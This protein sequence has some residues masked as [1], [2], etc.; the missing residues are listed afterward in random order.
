[1]S[2]RLRLMLAL[3]AIFALGFGAL[4]VAAIGI[5]GDTVERNLERRIDFTLKLVSGNP[6][7]FLFEILKIGGKLFFEMGQGQS[8][9]INE[10]LI[11]NDY[12]EIYV[13]KDYQ[14]IDRVISGVKT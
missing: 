7:F 8:K 4:G 13:F 11:K 2:L 6:S 9:K 12:K 5:T 14:K 1:M 3:A 10:L